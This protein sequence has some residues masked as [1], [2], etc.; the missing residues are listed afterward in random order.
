MEITLLTGK[1]LFIVIVIQLV[2]ENDF[3]LPSL[4]VF[5][6]VTVALVSPF[7]RKSFTITTKLMSMKSH[8]YLIAGNIDDL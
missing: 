6:L 3:T 2:Q 1:K 4:A 8:R 5:P 7:L